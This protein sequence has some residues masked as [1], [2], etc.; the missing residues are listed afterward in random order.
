MKKRELPT[1]YRLPIT[2]RSLITGFVSMGG[3]M[4]GGCSKELPPTYGNLLRM[5]DVL[6]YQARRLLLPTH[7][8]VKEYDRHEISSMP[9]TGTTNPADSAQPAFKAELG[10]IYERSRGNQ[11]ADWSLSVEGRVDRPGRYTLAD[12]KRFPA[13][14]QITRHSCEEGWSSIAEWTGVTL[15]RV[16]ES[17]GI[18]SSA[19][20]VNFH[21]YDENPDG[22][23][24]FDALH[25]QTILAYGMN[26]RDLPVSHG[27][28]LRVRVE[29]QMGYK[30]VKFLRR[31][32]V[33]NEFDDMGPTGLLQ[34]GWSW[35]A[36]I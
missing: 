31:I 16:L 7:A 8:L 19:R 2:R 35:Y 1:A 9:A 15:R 12:L 13:R 11:F 20:F 17:A 22:I 34:T 21:P 4:L 32:V 27:A 28:P 5:G 29:T 3:L 33:A 18:Q 6:T 25:P 10:P 36:G 30:S 23:D 14:T 26:G 24:M